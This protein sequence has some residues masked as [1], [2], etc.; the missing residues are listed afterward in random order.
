VPIDRCWSLEYD[1]GKLKWWVEFFDEYRLSSRWLANHRSSDHQTYIMAQSISRGRKEI[2]H[3]RRGWKLRHNNLSEK[4]LQREQKNYQHALQKKQLIRIESHTLGYACSK[5]D[6]TKA[7]A[8]SSKT[9]TVSSHKAI[10]REEDVLR[11]QGTA[12]RPQRWSLMVLIT[13]CL[14][15]SLN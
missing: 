14:R 11:L 6:R 2:E 8:L 1:G 10:K 3:D 5:S 13:P 7:A 12:S 15:Q 9:T 4:G